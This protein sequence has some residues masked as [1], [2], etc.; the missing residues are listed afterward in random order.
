MEWIHNSCQTCWDSLHPDRF[1]SRSVITKENI[2]CF[3][4]TKTT[5]GIYIRVNPKDES[6]KHC[7]HTDSIGE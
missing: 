1:P 3:C 2:C 4:G 7:N 5:S 6:L